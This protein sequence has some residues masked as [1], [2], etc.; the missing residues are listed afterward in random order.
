M[1]R[2]VPSLILLLVLVP[3][4]W[5]QAIPPAEKPAP[6]AALRTKEPEP[7]IW[8]NFVPVPRGAPVSTAGGGQGTLD[9]GRI[10]CFGG[11][12]ND[13]VT[14][15]RRGKSFVV[16]TIFGL[17]VGPDTSAGTAKLIG[18]LTQVNATY[19]IAVDGIRLAPTP[20]VIQMA[21]KYGAVTE[22]RLDIEIPVD[23]PEVAALLLQSVAFQVLPN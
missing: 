15:V 14:V 7:T 19:R 3:A 11:A 20:Q 9:L 21:V 23:N 5:G 1:K 12:T 4:L 8:V 13:G 16:S 18:L 6:R 17:R 10:S 22:H 2:S